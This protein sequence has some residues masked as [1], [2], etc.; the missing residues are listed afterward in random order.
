M[1]ADHY[2]AFHMSGMPLMPL[3]QVCLAQQRAALA[4]DPTNPELQAAAAKASATVQTVF[5]VKHYVECS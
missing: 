1:Y 3:H 4:T 2:I 5:K